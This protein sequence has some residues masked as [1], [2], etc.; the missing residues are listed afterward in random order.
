MRT[1]YVPETP[2]SEIAHPLARGPTKSA[3]S[4]ALPSD[5]A[6]LT[7]AGPAHRART[8]MSVV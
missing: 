2:V 6:R 8:A 3:K 5:L 4:E 7:I 1:N